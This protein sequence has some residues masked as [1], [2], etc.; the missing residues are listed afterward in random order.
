MADCINLKIPEVNK[1]FKELSSIFKSQNIAYALLSKNNGYNLD[2]TLEGNSSELFQ[3]LKQKY[4][5]DKAIKEKALVYTP[6]FLEVNNW[7]SKGE[8]DII[9]IEFFKSDTFEKKA[10]TGKYTKDDSVYIA[11]ETYNIEELQSSIKQG[12]NAFTMQPVN[13][14]NMAET[15]IRNYLLTNNFEY[16][17]KDNV[18]FYTKKLKK[19]QEIVRQANTIQVNG[20]QIDLRKLG[21]NFTPTIDQL[22][23]VQNAADW[24]DGKELK[25]KAVHTYKGEITSLKAGEGYIYSTDATGELQTDSGQVAASY[26]GRKKGEGIGFKN[27]GKGK[28]SYGIVTENQSHGAIVNQITSFYKFAM[29]YPKAKFKVGIKSDEDLAQAFA[30]AG[31]IPTNV[32]FK[33]T[34]S[35]L[36][37]DRVPDK[38]K[39]N[40]VLTG[41]A[42]TGKTSVT[43]IIIE[44]AN[45]RKK[46]MI[47]SATTH[48]AVKVQKK[49]YGDKI[50]ANTLHSALGLTPNIQVEE[51][52]LNNLR[53]LSNKTLGQIRL[54]VAKHFSTKQ[55]AIGAG[56]ILV[57]DEASMVNDAL[58]EYA[59]IVAD[60]I[61]FKILYIGDDKQLK[62][63][64]KN[65]VSKV[66]RDI[67]DKHIS[68]LTTQVRQGSENS[69]E[70]TLNKL[71][72]NQ[73]TVTKPLGDTRTSSINVDGTEGIEW[74]IE[75]GFSEAA[76]KLFKSKEFLE[77]A[78]HVRIIAYRNATVR[79]YNADIRK[80]LGRK[81]EIELNEVLMAYD[82]IAQGVRGGIL[83][84]AD[85]IVTNKKDVFKEFVHPLEPD[86]QVNVPGIQVTLQDAMEKDNNFNYF[87]LSKNASLD[88]KIVLAKMMR[89]TLE[90][91]YALN[92]SRSKAANR[93]YAAYKTFQN[94]F[95]T[96]EDLIIP[97]DNNR[98][99]R[100]PNVHKKKSIDYGYAV[101]SHKSQGSTYQYA[102]VDEKDIDVIYKYDVEAANQSKYVAFSRAAKGVIAN[103]SGEI[104]NLDSFN[105][106]KET[107]YSEEVN[108]TD[109]N[110]STIQALINDGL[111]TKICK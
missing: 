9:D 53:F 6:E 32:I 21:F 56:D 83:N 69:L 33:E 63:V 52:D 51:F 22:Q 54:D 89:E 87:I 15:Q 37:Y 50:S 72:K 24:I 4:G 97:G 99:T 30:D 93:L 47:V 107:N 55:L 85:Y 64:K 35:K 23:A 104:K 57:I 70:N 16:N 94:S 45:Q 29:N 91:Y 40:F 67:T 66:F 105:F 7:I 100:A 95:L 26:F 109:T 19:E 75:S 5:R 81:E 61:G 84:S 43:S 108:L 17:E 28:Q 79:N 73:K 68:R 20:V 77:D 60:Y 86:I 76:T 65:Y 3:E 48:K 14:L 13:K 92:K 27:I 42:G 1:A 36:I 11:S 98:K 102:L 49:M 34:F 71:R 12:T 90:Q 8:P 31:N 106:D 59:N 25:Q 18:G 78:N 80:A 38:S 58:Y 111:I 110:N 88:D 46:R 82:T 2:K 41:S 74:V 44:Y 101:T 39:D 103:T 96:F 10:N 62:P